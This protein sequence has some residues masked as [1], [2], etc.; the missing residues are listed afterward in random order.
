M[1]CEHWIISNKRSIE[2]QMFALMLERQSDKGLLDTGRKIQGNSLLLVDADGDDTLG[3]RNGASSPVES[4]QVRSDN[5]TL[6]AIL[7]FADSEHIFREPCS[8]SGRPSVRERD[9]VTAGAV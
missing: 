8:W 3:R 4:E 9:E 2:V 6:V 7:W 5:N 1:S